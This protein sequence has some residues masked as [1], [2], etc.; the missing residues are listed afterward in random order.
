MI[1]GHPYLYQVRSERNG[2]RVVQVFEKY[3]GRAEKYNDSEDNM[4]QQSNQEIKEVNASAAN[5]EI[6][7]SEIYKR[8]NGICWVCNE[9][10]ELK[11][12][13]LGHLVDRCNGGQDVWENLAVMH[14]RC[15]QSKPK[16]NTL[17]EA[18]IWKMRTRFLSTAQ[19]SMFPI[20]IVQNKTY[21]YPKAKSQPKPISQT[22]PTTIPQNTHQIIIRV[23][24]YSNLKSNDQI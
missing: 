4:E 16:H 12:Y 1:K 9:Y 19:P 15:N 17:E 20:D 14:K 21:P 23:E 11:D 13:D 7:R 10:V 24:V 3:L 6:F 5:W 22:I 8:D 18:M 2:S